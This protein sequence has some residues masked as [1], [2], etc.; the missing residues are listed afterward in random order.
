MIKDRRTIFDSFN[1]VSMNRESRWRTSNWENM[2]EKIERQ[3]NRTSILHLQD[4]SIISRHF[5]KKRNTKVTLSREV[6]TYN[7]LIIPSPITIMVSNPNLSFIWLITT[8]T[9]CFISK[10]VHGNIFEFQCTNTNSIRANNM[11]QVSFW[12][13]AA[14]TLNYQTWLKSLIINGILCDVF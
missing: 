10:T 11:Y 9:K 5:E 3:T 1:S 14:K 12:T 8:G 4:F 13:A 6:S 7:K 2:V